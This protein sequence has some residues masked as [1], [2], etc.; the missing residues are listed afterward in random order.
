[1]ILGTLNSQHPS[2]KFTYEEES[3]N[4][5]PFLDVQ[6]TKKNSKL[7]T[8]I[9]MKPTFTGLNLRWTSLTSIKYKLGL[10]YS[11]LNRAWK[12]CSDFIERNEDKNNIKAILMKNE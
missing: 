3:N 4:R 12:I 6:V 5:L 2:I 10:I 9:Y 8:N 11:L 1:M 7:H